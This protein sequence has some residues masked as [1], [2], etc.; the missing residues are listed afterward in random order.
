MMKII[1]YLGSKCNLN[2]PYCHRESSEKEEHISDELINFLKQGEYSIVFKGGEPTL[3]MDDIKKVVD[4]VKAAEFT[5]HTNGVLLNQ[6]MSYFQEHN[7]K[8]LISYDGNDIRKFEPFAFLMGYRNIGVS[9]TLS[10]KNINIEK[11]L[12]DFGRY[13]LFTGSYLF[14]YPHFVHYTNKDNQEY[15]LTDSEYDSVFEQ[16]KKCLN[17]YLSDIVRF[18]IINKRYEGL[19]KGLRY[20]LHND[21]QYGETFC[22][23]SRCLRVDTNGN[24]FNCLYIRN[25]ILQ[26]DWLE[27]QQNLI[28]REFPLCKICSVY[29][30]CGAGC[31]KS[32]YH[33][34]ECRFY[35]KM[36]SWFKEWYRKNYLI[37]EGAKD[38]K[39]SL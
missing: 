2:C 19:F 7:F 28:D 26:D 23:N 27:C 36:Y 17:N 21:Y 3:Y 6:Y 11:I 10:H 14:F 1:I 22:A 16:Y 33:D 39:R 32:L 25:T 35:K 29:D 8:I 13:S 38:E 18:K 37:L 5:V 24:R 4:N 12:D 30:M 34:R 31:V 20:V 9:C 15:A